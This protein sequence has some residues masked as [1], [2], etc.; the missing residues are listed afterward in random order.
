MLVV[1]LDGLQIPPAGQRTFTVNQVDMTPPLEHTITV[2]VDST[3]AR[4]ELESLAEHVS[5]GRIHLI[6]GKPLFTIATLLT[7]AASFLT[8]V[9]A[10]VLTLA[11]QLPAG[12]EPE[13]LAITKYAAA[14]TAIAL[15]GGQLGKALYGLAV[16]IDGKGAPTPLPPIEIT[17]TDPPPGT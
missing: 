4:R 9:V 1:K 13:G 2:G 12:L 10:A 17:T 3:D 5:L 11:G 15:V 8:S 16:A 6:S 14:L 7:V